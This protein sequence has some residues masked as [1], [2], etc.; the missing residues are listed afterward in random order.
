MIIEGLLSAVVWLISL[1]FH[2]INFPSLP[3]AFV[4]FWNDS[5]AALHMANGIRILA[6]YTHF[7]F[8]SALFVVSQTIS[9]METAWKL[10]RW[11]LRKIPFLGID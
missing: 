1:L 6:A 9:A 2:A 3:E 7:V 11:V 4:T 5:N 10:V 8:L